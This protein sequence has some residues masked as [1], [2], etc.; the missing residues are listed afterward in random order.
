MDFLTINHLRCHLALEPPNSK[1]WGTELLETKII[2]VKI[3]EQLGNSR[4]F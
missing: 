4:L 3:D 2:S 1:P